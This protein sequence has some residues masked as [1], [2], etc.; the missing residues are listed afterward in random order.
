MK[1]TMVHTMDIIEPMVHT[2]KYTIL[3]IM[4]YTMMYTMVYTNIPWYTPMF[5]DIP[6][7]I[8]HCIGVFN[9]NTTQKESS[10]LDILL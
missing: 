6:Y 2:L 5:H 1:Y 3:D 8:N 9:L 7:G 10:S 4:E